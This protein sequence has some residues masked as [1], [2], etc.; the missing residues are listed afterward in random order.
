M[1][2][3]LTKELESIIKEKV[4]SGLY[5]NASEVVR[6]ALRQMDRYD[7]LFYDLKR[8]QLLKALEEGENSGQSKVTVRDIINEFQSDT[9]IS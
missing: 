4:G 5:G 8:E 9:S 6:D 2:I 7:Q 3:S 1:H